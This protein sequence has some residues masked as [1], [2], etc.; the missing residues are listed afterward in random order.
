MRGGKSALPL[1]VPTPAE[2]PLALPVVVL[3]L[4]LRKPTQAR[5]DTASGTHDESKKDLLGAGCV[6]NS[7]LHAVVVASHVGG[8]DVVQR[9]HESVSGIGDRLCGGNHGLGL[10]K[11]LA[12]CPAAGL[13][14]HGAVLKLT[15]YPDDCGLAVDLDLVLP[16][17]RNE[18]L[19]EVGAERP[20]FPMNGSKS[21]S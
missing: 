17:R 9:N 3:D 13:V 1:P 15:I 5:V 4:I 18:F 2:P 7:H 19:C 6:L 16:E 21:C 12:H 10:I 8:V 20:Q 14:P 11:N